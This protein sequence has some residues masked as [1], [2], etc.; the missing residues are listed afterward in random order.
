MKF[1]IR[2]LNICF[3]F[4]G[5]TV[6]GQQATVASGGDATGTGGSVAYSLGQVDYIQINSGTGMV[7]QGVQQAYEIFS[8]GVQESKMNFCIHF[9]PN[10]AT[11]YL[12]LQVE[13]DH[14]EDL[15]Y[16]LFDLKGKLILPKQALVNLGKIDMS[17][18]STS[19]YMLSVETG[20]GEQVQSFK[21]IKH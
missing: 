13:G 9:F 1:I 10:P 15:Y 6:F 3:W 19:T 8:T 20:E 17:L 7:H 12:M 11:E 2:L 16:H 21:I 4:V 5:L 14:I 18:L